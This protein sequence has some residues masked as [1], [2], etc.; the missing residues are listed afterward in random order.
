MAFEFEKIRELVPTLPQFQQINLL[1]GVRGSIR[2]FHWSESNANHWKIVTVVA[3]AV[4]DVVLDMR[5]NSELLGTA[6]YVDMDQ[7]NQVSIVIPPGFAHGMQTLSATSSTIY[8]TSVPYSKNCENSISPIKSGFENI[9]I[10]PKILS[11]RD[12]SSASFQGPT[13]VYKFELDES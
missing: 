4:R 3:G 6:C 7:S 12:S 13:S 5:I 10:E 9:W 8:A 1:Q 2:G 11:D